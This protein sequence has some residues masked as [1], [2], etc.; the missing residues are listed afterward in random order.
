MIIVV[1]KVEIPYITSLC[2]LLQWMWEAVW[3]AMP[4]LQQQRFVN[5]E[6]TVTF[7]E[8]TMVLTGPAWVSSPLIYEHCGTF[9]PI[10]L[11]ALN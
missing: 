7:G 6:V 11:K 5:S 9:S 2:Y 3:D 8:D 1:Q 4:P 10:T